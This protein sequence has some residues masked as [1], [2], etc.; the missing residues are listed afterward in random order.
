M[1]L[2]RQQRQLAFDRVQPL[3][4]R[5]RPLT[6]DEFLGQEHFV[7]P[8][9]LLRR[10]LT[11]DRLSS[12][13]FYGPPGTGKTTLAHIIA[14]HTKAHCVELNA[15]S[16]SVKDVR[17]VI[18]DAKDRLAD[19]GQRTVLFLDE[20]HRFN[21]AQQDVLLNDVENGLV[22]LV[23]ATT[24]N[25]FFAVN[26]PLVSRSQ[27]FQFE[28]L[29]EDHIRTL[30]RRAI[31]DR[32]RGLGRYD[33]RITDQALNH[34]ARTSDG[35]ARRAL[36]A[37]E[38]AVLSQ[39]DNTA[40]SQ[41]IR[42]PSGVA[43]A[44]PKGEA[45]SPDPSRPNDH[46]PTTAPIT[47]DL[48][49]AEDSIQR[50]AIVY[51]PTGDEHYDAASA[52][53]KSMRGSDPDAAIYW[54]ARM[55]EAGEDP[56]FIARRVAI[57]A[58]EDVGNADPQALVVANAAAQVTLL[59]GMP[60]CQLPLAQAVTYIATAPK[61]N[62]AA[63][64]IWTACKD[65]REGRTVPVPKHLRDS[66]YPGSARLGHGQGY[67]YAHNHEGGFV[68]QDYLGVEKRYY[69]PTDRGHEARIREYLDRLHPRREVEGSGVEKQE[70]TSEADGPSRG[71][72]DGSIDRPP[73][74]APR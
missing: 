47:I 25:P 20:I 3:A 67:Q 36:L 4:V 14:L 9:K 33:I 42:T 74:D 26:S 70:P 46:T 59:V 18:E 41:P 7:G 45:R 35:D 37:L 6:L 53:I 48:K 19:S 57:C 12:A 32:E 69:V 52:L 17:A 71:S 24:E 39:L 22:I 51:D 5:M 64:A 60:E 21:R 44:K 34:L 10:L 61:S 72:P 30:L 31:A 2:F 56:R 1:D 62:A 16:A 11:A 63:I 55:L 38:V 65:V 27:I 13:I 29:T 66:H 15:A 68:D 49:V 28:T 23:G 8:G 50:K 58:A 73:G 43:T 40:G 54:L